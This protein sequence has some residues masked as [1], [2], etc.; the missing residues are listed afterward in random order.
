M[1]RALAMMRLASSFAGV[2]GLVVGCNSLLGNDDVS[3]LNRDAAS[4]GTG[5]LR[6]HGAQRQTCISGLW[7]DTG[8]SCSGA[9]L[10]GTCVACNPGAMQCDGPQPQACD[11]AGDWQDQGGPCTTQTC[12]GGSC[13]GACGQG[14]TGC[15]GQQPQTCDPTGAWQAIGS[16]CGTDQ[17]CVNG[18]CA[19]TCGP[20]QTSC[21][22][23]NT[24]QACD[25]TGQWATVSTCPDSAPACTLAGCAPPPASCQG[26]GDGV[27]HC[28]A[29]GESC[30]TSLAVTG[31]TFSRS[32]QNSGSGPTSEGDPASVSSFRLDKYDVT[33]GRFRAFVSAVL[34]ADGG[35]GW[36][37]PAGSGKHVHLNG[38]SGL[39][40]LGAPG[41]AGI[42]FE[43]GW[44]VADDSKIAPTDANL[45][46]C[47]P[48]STW[49]DPAADTESLPIDCVNWYEAYA[50]CIWDGGFLP[51]EAEW[52]Y[53]AAG[54]AQQR[55]YPW[56]SMDPGITSQYADYDCYY[57]SNDA[58]CA[59]GS[60]QCYP[61]SIAPVGSATSGAGLWGQLDL[62]GDVW[63]WTLDVYAP[64]GGPCVD[65][66]RQTP[67]TSPRAFRGSI[68]TDLVSNLAA[69]SRPGGA[70]PSSR[71]VSPLGFRCARTP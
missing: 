63:Q 7:L 28:G 69:S 56:G 16:P 42:P 45:S 2:A 38:G 15:N 53:A 12:S 68:Y 36:T 35:A 70:D 18:S 49:M 67:A 55:Q 11:G 59:C 32:Y 20:G 50:F 27:S 60:G 19:G 21:S 9:C 52:E 10:D 39:V 37:P 41:E 14:Q 22:G 44:N 43:S 3:L 47:L 23:G 54:G 5:E 24:Q 64:Y 61:G 58:V 4:C 57:P 40:D 46:S 29:A 33:V 48:Q 13:T 30:C 17:T 25:A 65:C 51:S 71:A 1:S 34:P 8:A 26:G 62:A 6:C 66:L 31:G